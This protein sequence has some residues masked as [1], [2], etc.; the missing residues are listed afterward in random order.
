MHRS[1]R[2]AIL[3]AVSL[4]MGST[5]GTSAMAAE[6]AEEN[7]SYGCGDSGRGNERCD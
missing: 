3:L 2:L 6:T 7:F 4:F 5:V 1:K